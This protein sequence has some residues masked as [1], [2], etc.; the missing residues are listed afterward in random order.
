MESLLA[1]SDKVSVITTVF[2]EER[3]LPVLIDALLSQS[4]KPDE[5]VIVDGGSSDRTGDILAEYALRDS[6]LKFIIE[7]GANIS[8]GRNIAIDRAFHEIVAMIDGGCKPDRFWLEELVRPLQDGYTFQVAAGFVAVEA[9]SD[10]E[11]VSGL[12]VLPNEPSAI[13]P[14]RIPLTGRSLALRK[15]VWKTIGGFPEWLYTGEDTL[16][17]N[18]I[19]TLGFRIAHAPASILHWRPRPTIGKLFKMFYLYGKGNGRIGVPVGGSLYHLR[20]YLLELCFLI[21]ALFYPIV[22]APLLLLSIYFFSGF[23]LPAI[24]KIRHKLTFRQA[25]FIAP[26]IIWVKTFSYTLGILAGNYDLKFVPP[27]REN[28]EKYTA[29]SYSAPVN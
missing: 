9:K 11:L 7:P 13:T 14:G 22:L 27:F 5:I 4:L 28:L 15:G 18:R 26:I 3:T 16:F 2:N 21:A 19:R 12:L 6:C 8:R 29:N 24:R 10:F 17:G 23:Y 20:N 1:M 25:Y